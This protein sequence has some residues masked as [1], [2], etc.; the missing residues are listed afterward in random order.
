M[1]GTVKWFN[2]AKGYGFVDTE[3]VGPVFVHYSTIDADGFRT[4]NEGESVE[5]EITE[6]PKGHHATSVKKV[7]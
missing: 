3:E 2:N 5:L 7:E 4:L 6:G 1:K